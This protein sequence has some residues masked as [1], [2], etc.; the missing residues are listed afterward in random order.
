M[1]VYAFDSLRK[2]TLEDQEGNRK[3]SK[4]GSKETRALSAP[5][6]IFRFQAL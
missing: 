3:G 2:Q 6:S 5:F 1:T 4:Q